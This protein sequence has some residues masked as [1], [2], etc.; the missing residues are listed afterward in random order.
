M[1]D[2]TLSANDLTTPYCPASWQALLDEFASKLFLTL[3][4]IQGVIVQS[5]TPGVSDQDK[6][7]IKTD[8]AIPYVIG[9]FVYTGGAWRRVPGQPMYFVDS[10]GA[11]NSIVI[12]TG[13]SIANAGYLTGRLWLIRVANTI[14]GATTVTVDSLGAKDLKK[15]NGADL[16][17]GEL[18]SGQLLLTAYDPTSD[19]FEVLTVLNTTPPSLQAAVIKKSGATGTSPQTISAN[20][21][22]T[23]EFGTEVDP[24]GFVSLS[25]NQFTLTTG[26][27]LLDLT[28]PIYRTASND[29]NITAFIRDVTGGNAALAYGTSFVAGGAGDYSFLNIKHVVT[30]AAS[31]NVYDVRIYAKDETAD[32]GIAAS[33]STY[34]ETYQQLSITKLA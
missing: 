28:I 31:S 18:S 17:S 24:D 1:P 9:A 15:A 7:W 22:T 25:A 14:T 27:Y 26:T 6:L 13:E 8:A 20:T 4:S 2:Y 23:V 10:S 34:D 12:T 5:A 30:I 16:E 3:P 33:A 32:L 21:E 19:H 11:A 29:S